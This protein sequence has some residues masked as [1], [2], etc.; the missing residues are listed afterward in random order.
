MTVRYSNVTLGTKSTTSNA[1]E[2]AKVVHGVAQTA[3]VSIAWDDSVVTNQDQL[4]QGV[5]LAMAQAL[6]MLAK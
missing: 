6:G 3:N 2:G 1:Y 5:R 4:I